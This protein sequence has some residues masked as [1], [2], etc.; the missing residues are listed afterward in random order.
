MTQPVP[1]PRCG[2]RIALIG[3]CLIL[4]ACGRKTTVPAGPVQLDCGQPFAALQ[5][6]VVG[7]PGLNAAPPEADEPIA[8]YSTADGQASYLIT[9]PG[10][11]AHPAILM[12]QAG[13]GGTLTNT[14]CA[15]GDKAAYD[16]LMTY[17]TGLKAAR[18]QR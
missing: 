5:A 12:Q 15:Y 1:S 9:K 3:A 13:A 7:Q 6:R 11:P 10:S 18:R 17:L 16:Q 8:A 14:G 4:A 2:R